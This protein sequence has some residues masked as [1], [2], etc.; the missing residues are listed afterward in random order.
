MSLF[1]KL[2]GRSESGRFKRLL[3][4]TRA[5]VDATYGPLNRLGIAIVG[6]AFSAQRNLAQVFGFSMEGRP[7]EPQI[8]MFYEFL[9]FFSHVA[10]RSVV[11]KGFTEPQIAKLQGCLGPL[12]ASTAVDS[13]FRHWPE[14]LK[15]K[16]NSEVYQK[17]ND[18][19]V[20]Y[21]GCR[22]LLS[23]DD[24]LSRDSLIGRVAG[25]VADL[26]ER[27][28][29]ELAK[30]AVASAASEAFGAMQLD[31]LVG[32]VAVVIDSVD[33]ELIARFWKQ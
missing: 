10:L 21:A 5:E 15:T 24:P 30:M 20:E 3:K 4:E 8:L 7:S 1:D 27:P 23:P 14:D 6:A 16:M 31:R 32:D 17:L 25:N 33:S 18:A 11:A 9:Y 22:G 12:L 28:S 29:D 19:E 26:W 13:F 2:F